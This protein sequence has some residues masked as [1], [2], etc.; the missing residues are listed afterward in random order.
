MFNKDLYTVK[1]AANI[2]SVSQQTIRGYIRN[3]VIKAVK[4]GDLEKS[5]VRIPAIELEKLIK[6]NV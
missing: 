6:N 5:P 1:E 3:G 2:F 4:I